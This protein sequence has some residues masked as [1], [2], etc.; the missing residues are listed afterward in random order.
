MTTGTSHQPSN[1]I[2]YSSSFPDHSECDL[3][4]YLG[5]DHLEP[6]KFQYLQK[7]PECLPCTCSTTSAS[8]GF[9]MLRD[10]NR[11]DIPVFTYLPEL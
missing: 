8:D 10:H 2:H 6:K 4:T 11:K 1:H 5:P 3:N 7:M 9:E